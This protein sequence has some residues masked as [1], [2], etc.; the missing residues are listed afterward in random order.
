MKIGFWE[1]VQNAPLISK[2]TV[3]IMLGVFFTGFVTFLKIRA[4]KI[5]MA[6]IANYQKLF[7]LLFNVCIG[8]SLVTAFYIWG[9]SALDTFERIE[10]IVVIST[11]GLV[12]ITEVILFFWASISL[13]QSR[14]PR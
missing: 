7:D 2:I 6:Q 11:L 12:L 4:K 10:A 1:F 14:K 8:V 13:G 9:K 3:V 5:S